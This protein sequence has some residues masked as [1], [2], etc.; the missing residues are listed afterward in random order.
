MLVGVHTLW[1]STPAASAGG[2]RDRTPLPSTVRNPAPAPAPAHGAID[3]GTILRTLLGL[4]VVLGIVY[5]VY[6]LLR[7]YGRSKGARSDGR[8]DVVA[9][10]ALGPTRALHLVRVGDELVLV[11][12]AESGVTPIRVYADADAERLDALLGGG[13]DAP[14]RPASGGSPGSWSAFVGDLRRRSARA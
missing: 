8:M 14:F 7:A 13:A 12:S 9:T 6:W 11:G 4:A 5:G 2:Y 10:T 1:Q 3:G